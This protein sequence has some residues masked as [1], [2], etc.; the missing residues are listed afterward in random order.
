MSVRYLLPCPCGKTAPVSASQAGGVVTCP[1][2]G[3][4]LETPRLRDLVRLPTEEAEAPAASS[5][6]PRQGVLTAGLLLAAALAGGGWWFAANEPQPPEPFDASI[7][8]ALVEKGLEEMSPTDLWKSYYA[9]YE[10]MTQRGLQ[11]AETR[12]DRQ[13]KEALRLSHL[14]QRVLFFAAGAVAV[15]AAAICLVLPK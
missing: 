10:P 13:T 11:R 3:E 1:A 14:Y 4:T 8:S 5:W 6:S 9:F 12:L 7:R 15:A 2:C